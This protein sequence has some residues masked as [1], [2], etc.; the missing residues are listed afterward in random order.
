ML[1]W[2]SYHSTNLHVSFYNYHTG[3]LA[4]VSFY[5]C[6]YDSPHDSHN[7]VIYRRRR[8]YS[9]HLRRIPGINFDC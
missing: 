2:H 6:H 3:E 7:I 4:Y 5:N 9:Y 8:S 1:A